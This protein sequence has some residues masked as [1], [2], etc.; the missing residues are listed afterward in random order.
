[1][2]CYIHRPDEGN[3]LLTALRSVAELVGE[4]IHGSW[5][6]DP[7]PAGLRR[8]ALKRLFG[9]LL[10]ATDLQALALGFAFVQYPAD[11]LLAKLLRLQKVG[12]GD[13]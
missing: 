1:M 5:F 10:V 9:H 12:V 13:R 7:G 4:W 8:P 11:V 6:R 3:E 2:Q